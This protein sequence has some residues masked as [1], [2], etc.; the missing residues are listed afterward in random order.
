MK[1]KPNHCTQGPLINSPD[2]GDYLF[3]KTSNMSIFEFIEELEE[4]KYY[5]KNVTTDMV[6]CSQVNYHV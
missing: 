5:N 1:E 4:G 6:I 3:H 2:W